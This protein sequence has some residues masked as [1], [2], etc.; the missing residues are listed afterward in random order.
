MTPARQLVRLRRRLAGRRVA[1]T[2]ALLVPALVAGL[3]SWGR[4]FGAPAAL[5][6]GLLVLVLVLG[7]VI[8]QWRTSSTA[9]L[10][11]RLDAVAP[12]ME[13]SADLL[14]ADPAHL[15]DM[16]RLQR[17]RLQPRVDEAAENLRMQWPRRKLVL[18]L[19]GAILISLPGWL[20]RPAAFGDVID[21]VVDEPARMA[22]TIVAKQGIDIEPPAYTGLPSRHEAALSLKAPAGSRVRWRL[23]F[24]PTPERVHL[25]FHDGRELELTRDG[26]DWIGEL[27][28]ANSLLYRIELSGH[29]PLP[30]NPLQRIDVIPDQPPS[31]RVIEPSQTLTLMRAEQT[32]WTIDLEAE[33]DYGIGAAELHITRAQGEGESVKFRE[34][35]VPLKGE[36][37]TPTQMRYRHAL[38][39]AALDFLEGDE[40]VVR[41]LVSDQREPE[42][43]STRSASYILRWPS[44]TMAESGALEGVL[45]DTMPGYFR[46]QRQIIIDS[47]ALLGERDQLEE[48]AF[49]R[50]SDVI[51]VD[52][53]ILRLRYGQFLG[54]ESETYGH[55]EVDPDNPGN[56]PSAS[57]HTDDEPVAQGFGD[58]GN[59]LA[60]YGHVHDT[61]EAATL[62]DDVTKALL[63][64]ALNAMWQAELHLR[65]GQPD[66]ALPYEHRALEAIKKVQQ[67]DRIYLARV[68]LEL[69]PLDEG[70]RLSG[71]REGLESRGGTLAAVPD[72]DN[73]ISQ[74]WAALSAGYAPDWGAAEGWLRDKTA[75]TPEILDVHAA[76]DSVRREPDCRD[77]RAELQRLLWPMLPTPASGVSPRAA[78]DAAERIWLNALQS[79]AEDAQ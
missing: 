73:S 4:I 21:V 72:V 79:A 44:A 12:C 77:C 61:R 63:R 37:L 30:E 6:F 3:F 11:R 28:L 36:Q 54:E 13:D 65:Q 51:G 9:W 47:E 69:P 22:G 10:A 71:E 23:A 66:L 62:L 20:Y 55:G 39:L 24:E 70:R 59:V 78:P 26:A 14:F 46:S 34:Q 18:S 53:R 58:A 43:N 56:D 38:D 5:T 2:L 48:A 60:E 27:T 33:D 57:E 40:L 42:P 1:I 41:A 52:Q 64:T 19:A 67:A 7:L 45:Q 29:A 25:A 16:Q 15:T 49:T 75:Q 32:T 76:I 74:L 17:R 8:H 31:L 35:T 50:R 68:G